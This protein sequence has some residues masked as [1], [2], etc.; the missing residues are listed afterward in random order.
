MFLNVVGACLLLCCSCSSLNVPTLDRMDAPIPNWSNG[1]VYPDHI[2]ISNNYLSYDIVYVTRDEWATQ[3]PFVL[4]DSIP[5]FYMWCVSGVDLVYDGEGN[6]HVSEVQ[7]CQFDGVYTIND[8]WRME[9]AWNPWCMYTRCSGNTSADL[10]IWSSKF[11]GYVEKPN[12]PFSIDSYEYGVGNWGMESYANISTSNEGPYY[13]RL[14]IDFLDYIDSW[15]ANMV[16]SVSDSAKWQDAY[17]QGWKIGYDYGYQKGGIDAS[18]EQVG[19]IGVIPYL[20]GGIA[21]VPINILNGLG[22]FV[23]WDIPILSVIFTFLFLALVLWI[24]KRFI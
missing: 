2:S 20:F 17:Q 9:P 7:F 14:S 10:S 3:Y 13:F 1:K 4:S 8:V 18:V 15:A 11:D 23:V 24:V 6:V 19:N 16:V 22:G 5:S 12:A 21:N